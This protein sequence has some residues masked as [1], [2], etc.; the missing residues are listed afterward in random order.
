MCRLEQLGHRAA[1]E[2]LAADHLRPLDVKLVQ[3]LTD[4]LQRE[5]VGGFRA[6]L[7]T[8]QADRQDLAAPV[9]ERVIRLE[10]DEALDPVSEN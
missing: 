9:I 8:E 6:G 5:V 4:E 1:S 7:I 10:S 2:H 3:L